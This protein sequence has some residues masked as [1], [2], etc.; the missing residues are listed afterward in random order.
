MDIET[1]MDFE[2][3]YLQFNDILKEA[4]TNI[5]PQYMLFEAVGLL[6]G[7]ME[8][9]YGYELY[10]QLRIFQEKF[11]YD[12]FTIHAEP[13]KRRTQFFKSILERLVKENEEIEDDV[14]QISVMPDVLVHIPNDIEGNIAVL[15]IKPEKG[16][17]IDGFKKDI[18]VLKEFID[19]GD[20]VRGYFRGISLL[21][22]TNV[23]LT[24]EEDVKSLYSKTIKETVGETWEDY[25]DKIQLLWHPGPNKGTIQINWAQNL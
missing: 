13:Q 12:Q 4:T 2:K 6:D 15:E 21:Y 3:L 14:F 9:T 11:G 25:Q 16:K 10:H 1:E 7:F 19:G 18:R 17:I 8:R 23:G 20:H 24:K 22:Y 5:A